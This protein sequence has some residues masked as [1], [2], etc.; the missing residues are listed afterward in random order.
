MPSFRSKGKKTRASKRFL[1]K[2]KKGKVL[3]GP[4]TEGMV[5]KKRRISF[6]GRLQK[7]VSHLN[8]RS[9]VL[10]KIRKGI[11]VSDREVEKVGISDYERHKAR[12]FKKPITKKHTP[13]EL[14]KMAARQS[15][16]KAERGARRSLRGSS[17]RKHQKKMESS[18]AI[19]RQ[20]DQEARVAE[21]QDQRERGILKG[22]REKAIKRLFG[23]PRQ[24]G[25]RKKSVMGQVTRHILRSQ[26]RIK[27]IDESGFE[28]GRGRT[29]AAAAAAE[30]ASGAGLG[31][32]TRHLSPKETRNLVKR[33][34]TLKQGPHRPGIKRGGAMQFREQD[35]EYTIT[36]KTEWGR[37][38][39]VVKKR[40]VVRGRENVNMKE[41]AHEV[42]TR[43]RDA[44][45]VK[46]ITD[47]PDRGFR[48]SK[49][50]GTPKKYMSRE[51]LGKGQKERIRKSRLT[52]SKSGVRGKTGSRQKK[53]GYQGG[54]SGSFTAEQ[55][56]Q[57]QLAKDA[58]FVGGTKKQLREALGGAPATHLR[59][60]GVSSSRQKEE[61]PTEKRQRVWGKLSGD[62]QEVFA[63][64]TSLDPE[65]PE[66]IKRATKTAKQMRE[67]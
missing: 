43:Q 42:K 18:R 47:D 33:Q 55:R 4:T 62:V 66:D 57:L 53:A 15:L 35:I 50:K 13:A 48:V 61:T 29:S 3:R 16:A 6:K 64:D 58:A 28:G 11:D 30:R 32:S 24:K 49:D 10:K 1:K 37:S 46:T 44:E 2:P 65:N 60:R 20:L 34:S 38:R 7:A 40:R 19:L 12:H 25:S 5:R 8:E 39:D 41:L 9:S 45:H 54:S 67:G 63:M 14:K 51:E 31:K 26:T 22:R 17:V 59:T 21:Q 36:E 23:D 52:G 27:N 56:K